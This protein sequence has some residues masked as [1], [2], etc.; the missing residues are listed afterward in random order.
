M[1]TTDKRF[2]A[3]MAAMQG[4]LSGQTSFGH[5]T[6]SEILVKSVRQADALLAELDRTEPK[7]DEMSKSPD[8]RIGGAYDCKVCGQRHPVGFCKVEIP[9][10]TPKPPEPAIPTPPKGF[11]V[12]GIGPLTN[13]SDT[14]IEDIAMICED[15]WELKFK[16]NSAGKIYALRD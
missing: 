3:A 8:Q 15:E 2:Q 4:M 14:F 9:F 7:K 6:L 1:N 5:E 11:T 13:P 10:V 16:G 12:W